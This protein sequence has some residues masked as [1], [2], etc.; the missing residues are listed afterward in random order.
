MDIG[1]PKKR[2]TSKPQETPI[3]SQMPAMPIV[4]PT[5]TLVPA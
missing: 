2:V 1:K 4:A 3:P 5:P